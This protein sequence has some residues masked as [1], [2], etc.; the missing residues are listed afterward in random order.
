MAA[1]RNV[2]IGVLGAAGWTNLAAGVCGRQAMWDI[3]W[4]PGVTFRLPGLSP[5]DN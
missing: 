2:V 1:L 5:S 3:G 4:H